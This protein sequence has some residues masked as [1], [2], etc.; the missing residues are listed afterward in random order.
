MTK[1]FT[2]FRVHIVFTL[3]ILLFSPNCFF[4]QTNEDTIGITIK[5][6]VVDGH[7]NEAVPFAHIFLTDDPGTG[8]TTDFEGRFELVLETKPDSISA[9]ALGFGT[10][11]LSYK[12]QSFL[13]FKLE[14]TAYGLETIVV[15]PTEDP[16]VEIFRRV[17]AHKKQ[18]NPKSLDHYHCEV[19]DKLELDLIDISE[20]FQNLA[21]NRP[22]KFAFTQI[23]STSEE[24]PFLPAFFI[25]TLSDYYYQRQP[26]SEK[27]INKASRVSGINN[28]SI[29]QFLEVMYQSIN[30]YDNW[31]PIL[32]KDFVSPISDAGFTY[33]N[34]Y[35]VDSA[36]IQNKWCYQIQFFPK[37]KNANTFN[38]DFWVNDTTYAV[39]RINLQLFS[40]ADLNF[41]E[42]ISMVQNFEHWNDQH[43]LP[44]QEFTV[45]TFDKISKPLLLNFSKKIKAGSPGMQ[46]KRTTSYRQYQL[47]PPGPK[48]PRTSPPPETLLKDESFWVENRHV[49]LTESEKLAEHLIDTIQKVK[50]FQTWRTITTLVFSGFVPW[51]VFDIGNVYNFYNRNPVEG[52][53][54]KIGLRTN[55]RFSKNW[56]IASYAAYGTR[57][58]RFK[59][60][61]N[62]LF[63]FNKVPRQSLSATVIH[64][65]E[66]RHQFDSNFGLTSEGVVGA[67]FVRR[68]SV[69][70]KLLDIQHYRLTYFRE[71]MTG[72]SVRTSIEHQLTDPWFDF[73]YE[74]EEGQAID[75]FRYTAAGV[76]LRFAYKEQFV[77]GV[78]NRVSL[79]SRFPIV[80]VQ[81]KLG[82][83]GLLEGDFRFHRLSVDFFDRV[84]L[85][86]LGYARIDIT[87]GKLFG[88]VPWLL[89]YVPGGNEGIFSSYNGF[90]L[91]PNF[92]FAADSWVRFAVDYH[93]EGLLFKRLLRIR[94]PNIR[95]VANFRLLWGDMTAENRAVSRFNL[96]ENSG[97][98]QIQVPNETPYME[99][100]AGIENILQVLRVDAIWGLTHRH[101]DTGRWGVRINFHIKF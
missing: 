77:S 58:E 97:L 91:T 76:R 25:E 15:R 35:L 96:E 45:I 56:L 1:T 19:Y 12:E 29:A 26:K 69:P 89:L 84:N 37:L 6:Q 59:F 52:D 13:T 51:K 34:Y 74:P 73:R 65:V 60:G 62:T 50:A 90:N 32:T 24:L 101:F 2:T 21:I 68:S 83:K 88:E 53:R 23:D 93:L 4:A 100:S 80:S 11:T 9:S 8:T 92:T 48:T 94:K 67:N 20:G 27:S 43:W 98:V 66:L 82:I 57:D 36:M 39:K 38:G 95:A 49:E 81:Y 28:A 22:F 17:L 41:V 75:S 40:N 46:G 3:F 14:A 54:F 16:A 63:L 33:Y 47:A 55:A 30:P 99:V 79:N 70:F 85:P 71:N 42:K 87:A 7:L 5:G 61:V 86:P 44:Q 31:I 78:F 10:K 64:D 18:N 72:L